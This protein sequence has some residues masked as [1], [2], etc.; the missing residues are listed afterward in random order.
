[1]INA[2]DEKTWRPPRTSE[3]SISTM[4][5]KDVI[6]LLD[7]VM[8]DQK[9]NG[10]FLYLRGDTLSD[11]SRSSAGIVGSSTDF[12]LAGV[13]SVLTRVLADGPTLFLK[14]E[15]PEELSFQRRAYSWE[16]GTYE[17][18]QA[19][20]PLV[21]SALESVFEAQE[22]YDRLLSKPSPKRPVINF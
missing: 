4:T 12:C 15:I 3:I 2:H 20:L 11:V 1:M 21:S 17:H 14:F 19:A 10:G 22:A 5:G 6:H 18:L 16:K 13:V 9:S 8:E 7:K